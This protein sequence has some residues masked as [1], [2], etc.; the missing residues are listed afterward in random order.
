MKTKLL[1]L[2]MLMP[3]TGCQIP[4]IQWGWQ[5]A[6]WSPKAK[7][8]AARE[9]FNGAVNV[10]AALREQGKFTAEEAAQITTLIKGGQVALDQWQAAISLG[11]STTAYADQIAFL[12]REMEAAKIAAERKP[13]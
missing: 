3:L 10:M 11:Q 7:L 4:D 5:D 6:P 9:G 2:F 13:V 12:R 1:Y 8:A